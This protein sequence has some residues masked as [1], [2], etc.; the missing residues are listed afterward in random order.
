[1]HQIQRTQRDARVGTMLQIY[2]TDATL[3][4][5]ITDYFVMWCLLLC[6]GVCCK[7]KCIW[8]NY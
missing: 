7:C 8:W 6:T 4:N 1:M 2:A 5:Q 3:T